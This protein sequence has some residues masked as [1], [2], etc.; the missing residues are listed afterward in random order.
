MPPKIPARVPRVSFWVLLMIEPLVDTTLLDTW[1]LVLAHMPYSFLCYL[2]GTVDFSA[3]DLSMI[4][5]RIGSQ[6]QVFSSN[7][8]R[9]HGIIQNG[10]IHGHLRNYILGSKAFW[11]CQQAESNIFGSKMLWWSKDVKRLMYFP[12]SSDSLHIFKEIHIKCITFIFR[13][14]LA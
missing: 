12:W 11:L 6:S 13:N 8:K 7:K 10:A 2:L 4:L 14:Q 3:D 5:E 9:W 1:V